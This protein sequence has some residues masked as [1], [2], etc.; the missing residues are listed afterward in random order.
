[1]KIIPDPVFLKDIQSKR[2]A[3]ELLKDAD[4]ILSVSNYEC[5]HYAFAE[6]LA[7]GLQGFCRGDREGSPQDFWSPYCYDSME[8]MADQIIES[9]QEDEQVKQYQ[10][11]VNREYIEGNF[12]PEKIGSGLIDCLVS[13]RLNIPPGPPSKGGISPRVGIVIPTYNHAYFLQEAMNTILDGKYQYTEFDSDDDPGNAEMERRFLKLS[14][15][16]LSLDGNNLISDEGILEIDLTVRSLVGYDGPIKIFVAILEMESDIGEPT[17]R[18]NIVRKLLPDG[19]GEDENKVWSAGDTKTY[20]FEWIPKHF[21]ELDK[22]NLTVIAFLQADGPAL[23]NAFLKGE[24]LQSILVSPTGTN[25][26]ADA[27]GLDD[28]LLA[29]LGV[30]LYPNPVVGNIV[31]LE[32][33]EELFTDMEFKLVDQRGVTIDTGV[34]PAGR[35]TFEFDTSWLKNG[36]NYLMLGNED[37]GYMVKKLIVLR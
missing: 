30:S 4:I 36:M 35:R 17:P 5:F 32:F 21:T 37:V 22:D 24:I 27:T 34:L 26:L 20:S 25:V 28:E 18:A 14:P 15:F 23:D 19:T 11:K 9:V 13:N 10:S 3:N 31:N 33:S 6:G 8:A 16:E 1:M 7:A 12:S 29:G 2:I